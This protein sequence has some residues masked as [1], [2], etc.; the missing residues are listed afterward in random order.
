[1]L[2]HGSRTQLFL[3]ME[4]KVTHKRNEACTSAACTT[5]IAVSKPLSWYNVKL[6]INSLQY[7]LGLGKT[8]Q[9][10]FRVIVR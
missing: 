10:I 9:F 6:A 5:V 8:L 1:M 4:I 3:M 7:L 2:V